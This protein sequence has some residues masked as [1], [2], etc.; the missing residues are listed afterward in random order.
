ME[1]KEVKVVWCKTY[2]FVLTKFKGVSILKPNSII[3]NHCLSATDLVTILKQL[4]QDIWQ[5]N[6]QTSES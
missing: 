6:T 1:N 2:N 3:H 4:Q 5:N